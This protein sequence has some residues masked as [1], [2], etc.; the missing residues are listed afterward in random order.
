MIAEEAATTKRTLY[1]HFRSKEQLFESV[2][3]FVAHLSAANLAE[4]FALAPEPREAVT[5][6][7]LRYAY[8]S[9]FPDAIAMQRIVIALI[10][11]LPQYATLLHTETYAPAEANLA[12]F[13]SAHFPGTTWE[14][15]GNPVLFAQALMSAVTPRRLAMLLGTAAPYPAPS[16]L[17]G[18]APYTELSDEAQIRHTVSLFLAGA[19]LP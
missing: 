9:G 4:S 3:Y 18:N 1:N 10:P 16:D 14:P 19:I 7:C 8:W 6:F 11:R 5:Q 17:A 12:A 13:V 15:W 2:M